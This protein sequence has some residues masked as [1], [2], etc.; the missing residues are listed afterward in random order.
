MKNFTK[1][2]IPMHQIGFPI[3]VPFIPCEDDSVRLLFKVTEGLDYTRLYNTYSTLGRNPVIDP[4]ILFR[5]LIY[6]YM[7]K[8]YSSR[9]IEKACKRDINFI[10]LL[11]GQKAPDYN[12]IARFRVNRL[13]NCIDDLFNQLICKLG[14]MEEIKYKN[15]FIDGTK[16]EAN[17]NKYTFVWKKTTDK[18]EAKLQKKINLILSDI[19]KD[20]KIN[21]GKIEGKISVEKV[22]AILSK[23]DDIKIAN[24]I[25]FVQCKGKRKSALQKYIESLEEFIEK[26]SKYDDYNN[27]F[28]GRNSFS[29]TDKDATFMHMKEDH[30]KNGQLK[31]GYNIQIGVEGEYIVGI[32]I[33]SERSDQLTL[34]PFLDKL[35]EELP[36]KFENVIADAGYE[37]EENYRYLSEHKQNSYIKPQ[38]YEKSKSKKFKNDISKRENMN[39]DVKNDIYICAFGKRIVPVSTKYRTSKSG[40]IS[41]ITIYECENCNDCPYKN[42]CTKAKGNK[43]LHVSKDFIKYREKSLN[44]ITT[45]EGKLLRMNRSIQVECAF[46]VLKQDYGFR[47]FLLRGKKNIKIE[48]LLLCFAYDIKKLF[49]KTLTN[50]NRILLHKMKME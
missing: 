26:Q 48:F 36:V 49:N 44:K 17:A 33:S 2:V 15:I 18:F 37:S 22:K 11:Q 38:T 29:K 7:N 25:T 24:N 20:F 50:I 12:T 39:Y 13:E 30:M 41:E 10:W 42:T 4:V 9:E 40:Y 31:P 28:N 27:T 21:V 3:Q 1:N 43:R 32:D 6:G 34:I 47:R 5:I 35:E 16:I 19:F 14:K 45:H 8:L 46:G 23:L